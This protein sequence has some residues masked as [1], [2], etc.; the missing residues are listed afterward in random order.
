MTTAPIRPTPIALPSARAAQLLATLQTVTEQ[1]PNRRSGVAQPDWDGAACRSAADVDWFA[2]RADPG[3]RHEIKSARGVCARCPIQV[4]CLTWA[5]TNET[6][7]VWGGLSENERDAAGG[8]A[9]TSGTRPLTLHKRATVIT[10]ALSE[11]VDPG[12]I[13]D[14][15]LDA[16]HLPR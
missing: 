1:R 9:I 12:V 5:L 8:L 6:A 16:F 7:G 14:A 2:N 15:I 13:R 4:Q 11:G 10:D 3:G